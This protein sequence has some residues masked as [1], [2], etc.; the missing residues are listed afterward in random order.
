MKRAA[1]VS[2]LQ[3]GDAEPALDATNY[4]A[5]GAESVT[6]ITLSGTDTDFD[7]VDSRAR[8][9]CRKVR[10]DRYVWARRSPRVVQGD[11]KPSSS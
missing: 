9:C 8:Q 11:A 1:V 2:T 4:W 3:S 5:A 10:R 6:L 7:P